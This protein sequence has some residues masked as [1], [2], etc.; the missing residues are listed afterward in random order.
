MPSQAPRAAGQP[1]RHSKPGPQ[2]PLTEGGW[3]V[4][5]QPGGGGALSPLRTGDPALCLWVLQPP[6]PT[7][8]PES[9]GTAKHW[10]SLEL[11]RPAEPSSLS[12]VIHGVG[13][14]LKGRSLG[15]GRSPGRRQAGEGTCKCGPGSGQPEPRDGAWGGHGEGRAGQAEL[16][17]SVGRPGPSSPG[18]LSE[19]VW[20]S[21]VCQAQPRSSVWGLTCWETL[22]T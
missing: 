17:K 15:L 13:L 11:M 8:R 4:S 3:G 12:R 21:G 7:P 1:Q 2:S 9:A 19:P 16:P 6:A 22:G 14:R 18:A 5:E 20:G 10:V